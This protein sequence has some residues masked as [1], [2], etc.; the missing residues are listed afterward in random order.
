MRDVKAFTEQ[1][2]CPL[3]SRMLLFVASIVLVLPE[4]CRY[5]QAIS[6]AT[7]AEPPAS[8]TR[9]SAEIIRDERRGTTPV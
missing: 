1:S 4:L 5:V 7:T 9:T 3:S 8:C 6:S 2:E